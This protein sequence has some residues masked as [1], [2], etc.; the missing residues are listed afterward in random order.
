M[1]VDVKLE[2]E[3]SNACVAVCASDVCATLT[4]KCCVCLQGS[5]KI[6]VSLFTGV[7]TGRGRNS[8]PS[9]SNTSREPLN[10]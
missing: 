2:M 7:S 10:E 4:N 8:A 6:T 5:T 9:V 1:G 3:T